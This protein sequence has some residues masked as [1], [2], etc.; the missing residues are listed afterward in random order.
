MFVSS[1]PQAESPWASAVRAA[2]ATLQNKIISS[3]DDMVGVLFY[4]TV[5]DRNV[6]NFKGTYQLQ[7]LD[8]PDA[9][10]IRELERLIKDLRHFNETIGSSSEAGNFGNVLWSCASIF[11]PLYSNSLPS[12]LYVSVDCLGSARWPLSE[13]FCSPTRTDHTKA[14]WPCS[15]Q[16]RSEPE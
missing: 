1:S 15:G 5:K 12:V 7:T 16:P 4:N 10:K 8:V 13:S 14:M 3:E 2:S 6:A 9:E 11:G